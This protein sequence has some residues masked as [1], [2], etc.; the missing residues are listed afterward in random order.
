MATKLHLLYQITKYIFG[1]LLNSLLCVSYGIIEG[2]TRISNYFHPHFPLSKTAY[3]GDGSSAYLFKKSNIGLF[4]DIHNF[5][6]F[7][8]GIYKITIKAF[9]SCLMIKTYPS[10]TIPLFSAKLS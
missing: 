5:L 1:R 8:K 6:V 9:I 3:W 4:I 10:F 7:I 2:V